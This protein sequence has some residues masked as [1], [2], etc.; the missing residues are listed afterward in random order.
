MKRK[1]DF[2]F[3]KKDLMQ[4]YWVAKSKH[5]YGLYICKVI[6]L[7]YIGTY[8]KFFDE[9]IVADILVVSRKYSFLPKIS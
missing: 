8:E 3:F 6:Y 7:T 2:Y 5:K 1:K 9:K 4:P